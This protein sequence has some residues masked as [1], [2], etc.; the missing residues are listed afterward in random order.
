VA[1]DVDAR[2][3][4]GRPGM[5]HLGA[6]VPSGVVDD[7]L[8]REEAAGRLTERRE[9][10]W[11]PAT[12]SVTSVSVRRL[13]AVAVS[14][15][16]ERDADPAA[17]GAAAA[18][19]LGREGPGILGAWAAIAGERA[20]IAFLRATGVPRGRS[21]A[22]SWP[23]LGEEALRA[24]AQV[25]VPPLVSSSATRGRFAPDGPALLAAITGGLAWEDRR[26]MDADA[27]THWHPPS[28]R[29]IPLRYGEVDGEPA[30]VL[31][32]ARLQALLGVDEHPTI[33]PHR[34]PVVV[35][36]LSPA[37]RPVQRTRDLPGFW[38]GTYAQVRAEMRGR[39]PKHDW[40]QRPW[41]APPGR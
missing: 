36:L 40:P 26:V 38:R 9:V 25:W 8:A 21:G 10:D 14:E 37:G 18:E 24:T 22:G 29:P 15:R 33:G 41:E 16:R 5:L 3:G 28:G 27:P 32:A 39:Y 17:L 23:D 35:E 31:L 13:G 34:I 19:V 12:G 1:V 7:L 4:S 2:S 20:R 6:G 30:S 11:D